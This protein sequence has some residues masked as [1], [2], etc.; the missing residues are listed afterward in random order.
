MREDE[1]DEIIEILSHPG[2]RALSRFFNQIYKKEQNDFFNIPTDQ[3][4]EKSIIYSKLRLDG[5]KKMLTKIDSIILSNEK[6]K[7]S[8]VEYILGGRKNRP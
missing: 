7:M 4:Q 5:M 1:K 3:D 2:M 6:Q 8:M